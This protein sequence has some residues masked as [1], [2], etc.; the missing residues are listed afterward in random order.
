MMSRHSGYTTSTGHGDA[1]PE[2]IVLHDQPQ[3]AP[4]SSQIARP[5]AA[6]IAIAENSAPC[7]AATP[8]HARRRSAHHRTAMQHPVAATHHAVHDAKRHPDLRGKLPGDD[9]YSTNPGKVEAA[10]AESLK[11]QKAGAGAVTTAKANFP[12]PGMNCH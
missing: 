6:Q 2:K 10:A 3:G 9:A 4:V 1:K 11:A 5:S 7:S 12:V 8:S